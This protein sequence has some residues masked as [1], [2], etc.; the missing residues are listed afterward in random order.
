M[1][2]KFL[3]STPSPLKSHCLDTL[4]SLNYDKLCSDKQFEVPEYGDLR[5]YYS[6]RT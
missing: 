6:V 2:N 5:R 4:Y 1:V 3:V